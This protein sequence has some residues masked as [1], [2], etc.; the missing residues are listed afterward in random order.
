MLSGTAAPDP[1]PASPSPSSS[2]VAEAL[3]HLLAAGHC[4]VPHLLSLLYRRV[5]R[6][7]TPR[8]PLLTLV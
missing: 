4:T 3:C 2:R 1:E 6:T 5:H 8:V 7:D